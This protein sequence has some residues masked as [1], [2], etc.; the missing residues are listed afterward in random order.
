ML[1]GVNSARITIKIVTGVVVS[2]KMPCC[3]VFFLF[4]T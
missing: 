4:I 3:A 1:K 2:L